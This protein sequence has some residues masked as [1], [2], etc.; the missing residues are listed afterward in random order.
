MAKTVMLPAI[1]AGLY[2]NCTAQDKAKGAVDRPTAMARLQ[3]DAA[4]AENAVNN[5]VDVDLTQN[6]F[7]ALTDFV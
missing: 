2:C 7:D 5:N 4:T 6:Q 3:R 1:M